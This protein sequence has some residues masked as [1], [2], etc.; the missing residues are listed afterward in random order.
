MTIGVRYGNSTLVIGIGAGPATNLNSLI[1]TIARRN[2]SPLS[3]YPPEVPAKELERVSVGFGGESRDC[4]IPF[5]HPTSSKKFKVVTRRRSSDDSP[6]RRCGVRFSDLAE[7]PG[8]NW[9][10]CNPRD[11]RVRRLLGPPKIRYRFPMPTS[12]I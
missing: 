3:K 8:S 9:V 6:D 11:T 5:L 1:G 4:W 12:M 10:W 2:V 7:K